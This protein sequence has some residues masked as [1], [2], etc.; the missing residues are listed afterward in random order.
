MA[1]S[2][3]AAHAA[4]MSKKYGKDRLTNVRPPVY[5]PTGSLYLDWALRAGG[6]R[7]GRL[8]EIAGPKDAGKTTLVIASMIE[9]ARMFPERGVCYLD[10]EATF[11]DD[12]ATGMGLDCSDE[13]LESGRWAHMY[14][15]HSEHVSDMAYD[16]VKSGLYSVVVVD[17]IGAMES[18][19]TL[20]KSAEKAADAMGRNAK[21][22][23][24]MNKRLGTLARKHDCTVLL[25]NQLRA[26]L[27][28]VMSGDIS[29]GPKHLQHVTTSRISL[30][31]LGSAED[32]RSLKLPGEESDLVVSGKTRARVPR[33][34]SGLPGRTAEFFVNRIG[35]SEY[36]APGIDTADEHLTLGVK[37][38]SVKVGGSFYTLPDGK[39]VQGRIAAAQYVRDTPEVRKMI[40]ESL[41]FEDPADVIDDMEGADDAE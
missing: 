27:S 12:R 26:N 7:L 40:R 39:K 17:S 38:K 19:K 36:G 37:H 3:L 21:I 33:L 24:Q 1:P 29:A 5:V 13:A 16:Y 34:K 35:T 28:S 25:V 30:S 18:D 2:A 22:I 23:T 6:W 20:Q 15:E 14:P 11:E 10:M 9:F 4:S 8:Y 41:L 31:A 32:L